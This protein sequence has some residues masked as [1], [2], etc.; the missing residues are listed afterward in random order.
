[1]IGKDGNFSNGMH[2]LK[3]VFGIPVIP[4]SLAL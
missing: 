3:S 4:G 2:E 1:M